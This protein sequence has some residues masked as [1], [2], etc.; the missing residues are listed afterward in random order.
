M[1]AAASGLVAILTLAACDG[2]GD[3]VEQALRETAAANQSA[4]V[5]YDESPA[6]EG[7]GPPA[8]PTEAEAAYAEVMIREN[9]EAITTARAVLA[10]SR[11]PRIRRSAQAVIDNRTREIAELEAFV[12]S[13]PAE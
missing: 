6:P 7:A 3:P 11:D 5:T 10:E 13:S 1:R 2:G 8:A 12:P 4:T 9:R